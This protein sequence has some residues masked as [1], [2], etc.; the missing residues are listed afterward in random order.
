[1][2]LPCA[3]CA[4]TPCACTPCARTPCAPT[5]RHAPARHVLRYTPCAPTHAM[6]PSHRA[7][8]PA[9]HAPLPVPPRAMHLRPPPQ[10][11]SRLNRLA[12]REAS[13]GAA[14]MKVGTASHDRKGRPRSRSRSPTRMRHGGP[15]SNPP[16]RP[17]AT[18]NREV[19]PSGAGGRDLSACAVCLGR[20][21]HQ[22][23]KCTAAVLWDG[24]TPAY[25]RRDEQGRLSTSQG[26]PL[27]TEWQLRRGCLSASHDERHRCS[28]CGTATHGAQACPRGQA[29]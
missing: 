6:C 13:L 7:P 12:A 22:V 19:F 17:G 11:E 28:G 8:S 25:A 26:K 20:Q 16:G 10:M 5:A 18:R 24:R 29:A 3:P 4:C 9:R 21:S 1:M 14:S 27:C 23:A 15:Q 2:C